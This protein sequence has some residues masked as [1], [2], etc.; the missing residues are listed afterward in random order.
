MR[1]IAAT[2]LVCLALTP[3]T[4][5]C[6]WHDHLHHHGSRGSSSSDPCLDAF[7]T[8]VFLT[9]VASGA[10]LVL[11]GPVLVMWT[12]RTR[13]I[14][15]IVP[16]ANLLMYLL[17]IYLR[18]YPGG[19]AAR[20]RSPGLWYTVSEIILL[21]VLSLLVAVILAAIQWLYRKIRSIIKKGATSTEPSTPPVWASPAAS[22]PSPHPKA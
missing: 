21:G 4:A 8:T 11:G 19:F 1:R 13:D 17:S 16:L 10:I 15:W 5:W 22:D 7:V 2:L 6:D 12:R 20:F 9:I 18:A 14:L 3:A